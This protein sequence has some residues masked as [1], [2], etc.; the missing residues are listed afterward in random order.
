MRSSCEGAHRAHDEHKVPF[1]MYP[2]TIFNA[3]RGLI[4]RV[5]FQVPR[6]VDRS[7]VSGD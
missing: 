2:Y 6:R 3:I 1:R 4:A 5:S 7:A